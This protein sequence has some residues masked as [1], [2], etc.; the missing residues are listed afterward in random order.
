M[1]IARAIKQSCSTGSILQELAGRG[2]AKIPASFYAPN[3]C[4][5]SLNSLQNSFKMLTKDMESNG[6]RY[7]AYIRYNWN[8]EKNGLIQSSDNNYFQPKSYNET[9]G[10]KTRKFDPIT[11]SFLNNPLIKYLLERNLQLAKNSN[12]VEFNPNL[13]VGL[14]QIRYEARR[15]EPSYSSPP[16][17]HRDNEPLVFVHLMGLT[18]NLIG[19][20]NVLAE[21]A[22]TMLD[23]LR[24]NEPFDTL[25]INRDKL[26][27]VVP[28]GSSD[29][30]SANRDVLLVTFNNKSEPALNNRDKRTVSA[31]GPNFVAS[32][33][34][35]TAKKLDFFANSQ[36]KNQIKQT[37]SPE[38]PPAISP[39]P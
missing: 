1:T 39:K 25:A 30:N 19:G 8:P 2:Y 28:M 14:H 7:R 20:D 29:E 35:G 36:V 17:L 34:I 4:S 32:E 21:N 27:S 15:Y 3:I 13:E 33:F 22:A 10:D 24:L 12:L 5:N 16:G 18:Q 9:D 37:V 11:D 23:V 31:N 6:N 38:L 26:H